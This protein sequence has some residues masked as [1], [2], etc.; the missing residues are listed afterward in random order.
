MD[1]W[2]A[3]LRIPVVALAYSMVRERRKIR[4]LLE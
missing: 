3:H 2:L 1:E 4:C